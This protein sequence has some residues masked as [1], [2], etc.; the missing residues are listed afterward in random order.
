MKHHGLKISSIIT[1]L[2]VI[3]AGGLLFL[4]NADVLD[5]VYKP[6][7]FSWQMLLVALGFNGLFSRHSWFVGLVL[8]IAGGFFLL[9]KLVFLGML[10]ISAMTF[11]TKNGWTILLIFVGLIILFHSVFKRNYFFCQPNRFREKMEGHCKCKADKWQR[12]GNETGYLDMNH[13]FSGAKEKLDM[14]VF[15][16]GEVNCV[17]GGVE[18]DFYN[19]RL[20]EGISTLE[21]NTVF[22]GAVLFIPI[23]W[24]IEI[25]RDLVFGGF[26]DNRPKPDFE[27]DKSR[28]LIIKASSVFGGGEI[29]IKN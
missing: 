4:F 19:S 10:N 13:V 6:V 9:Q 7:V 18:L 24:N 25:R 23:D 14:E 20:A 28:T 21:I 5:P 1:G 12:Y 17:F 22:G 3:A 15:R 2:L 11:I 27:V 29:R 16:G 26:D 8:M